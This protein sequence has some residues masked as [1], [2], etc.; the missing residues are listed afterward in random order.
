LLHLA[1]VA[2][3]ACEARNTRSPAHGPG[4]GAGGRGGR[5][6]GGGLGLGFGGSAAAL[7]ANWRI[8]ASCVDDGRVKQAHRS[9]LSLHKPFRSY[10]LPWE[11]RL[12]WFGFR[13]RDTE[14][15]G[16]PSPRRDG[17]ICESNGHCRRSFRS[18][19]VQ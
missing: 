13:T 16:F 10:G 5:G 14:R 6:G 3:E 15:C 18:G 2:P 19:L 9:V 8:A 7:A 1:L 12:A 4:G 17:E 11:R